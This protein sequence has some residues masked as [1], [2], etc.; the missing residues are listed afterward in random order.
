MSISFH[1]GSFVYVATQEN[2]FEGGL[3]PPLVQF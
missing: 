2:T 1:S 3:L